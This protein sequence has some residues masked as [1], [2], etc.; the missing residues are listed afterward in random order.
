ML[1]ACPSSSASNG[2][3]DGYIASTH[4]KRG[5]EGVLKPMK[6][7]ITVSI[8]VFGNNELLVFEVSKIDGPVEISFKDLF[9]TKQEW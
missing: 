5:K 3:S 8:E 6:S 7:Q 2:Y 4:Y 9:L 1:E